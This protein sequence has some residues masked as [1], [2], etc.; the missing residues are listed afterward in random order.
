MKVG[1]CY[2]FY[3]IQL[4]ETKKQSINIGRCCPPYGN[5]YSYHTDLELDLRL[6][7]QGGM[8]DLLDYIWENHVNR[9]IFAVSI[10]PV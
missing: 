2:Q 8:R 5:I 7:F 6:S 9:L 1:T 4:V 3:N 10:F